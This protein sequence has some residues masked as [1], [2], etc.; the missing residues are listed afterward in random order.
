MV[1]LLSELTKNTFEIM[2]LWVICKQWL[3]SVFCF[4]IIFYQLWIVFFLFK[5]V[6]F[7]HE[8]KKNIFFKKKYKKNQLMLRSRTQ[9][10]T[11]F[12]KKNHK[13]FFCAFSK[14]LERSKII[15]ESE[16]WRLNPATIG[17]VWLD[18]ACADFNGPSSRF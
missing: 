4:P 13:S 9:Q 5:A 3:R 18:P 14:F 10:A 1:F 2:P 12:S 11:V 16:K 8:S 7:A 6:E 17:H 15:F